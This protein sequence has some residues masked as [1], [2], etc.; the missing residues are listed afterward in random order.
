MK[1]YIVRKILHTL[2][3][4]SVIVTTLFVLFHVL[5]IDTSDRVISDAL[6]EA[7]RH[8][9]DFLHIP[10]FFVPLT[11]A[12]HYFDNLLSGHTFVDHP[13]YNARSH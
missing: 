12:N 6:D 3:T 9:L 10:G 8:R 1:E 7:S 4:L 2:L 11:L 5:P 13:Q